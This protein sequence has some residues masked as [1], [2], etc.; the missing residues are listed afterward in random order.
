M[1]VD[2]YYWLSGLRPT[3]FIGMMAGFL[4]IDGPRYALSRILVLSYDLVAELWK[5]LTGAPRRKFTYCPSM[6]VVIAGYNEA[7]TIGATLESI[8][9]T[10]PQLDI[11]V[12]D[13]GSEDGMVDVARAFARSKKGITV[14]RR[15]RRGGKSSAM[16]YALGFSEAEFVV[17]LD[18]DSSLGPNA[19]W[20]IVQPFEDPRVGIVSASILPRNP[21]VNFCTWMQSYEYLH[22]IVVGREVAQR[23]RTLSI[24]SGAFAAI[25]RTAMERTGAWDV[26]PPEDFDLTLRILR[27]GYKIEFTRFAQ[28][29]TE[30]PTTFVG[31]I[32]QRMR[33]DQ[34][35]TVRN[36]IRKHGEM[37]QPWKPNGLLSNFLIAVEGIVINL[38]CPLALAVYCICLMIHHPNDITNVA[39]TLYAVSALFE[40][41]QCV[42]LMYYSDNIRRDA[43]LC[44][45]WPL[46]PFYQLLLLVV[47]LVS[48]VQE[49]FWRVS[50]KD[51]YVPKH[52][53]EATWRW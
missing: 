16:N 13:D 19:L 43:T 5:A 47:R 23:F 28:C 48:N 26:G 35:A 11:I 31:L 32:K 37:L 42:T 9:G 52:V 33:W 3:E 17:C 7:K 24:A 41:L 12:V 4:L 53:R 10:Y 15:P 40:L 18:A 21:W 51:N 45:M 38:C 49:L 36:F 2:W 25:R 22:T 34:G 29:F 8:Y 39:I 1:L 30:M 46:M 50:Y 14:L 6:T 44:L 20:E 27:C